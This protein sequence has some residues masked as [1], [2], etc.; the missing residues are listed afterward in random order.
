M[1]DGMLYDP[2]QRQVKV[3]GLLKFW[4]LHFSESVSSAIYYSSW[5]VTT[6]SETKY[7]TNL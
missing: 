2:I 6:D 3:S 4:R 7:K 1:H 5:Q